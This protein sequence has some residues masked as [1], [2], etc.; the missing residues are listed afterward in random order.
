M[1]KLYLYLI[2]LLACENAG[3]QTKITDTV[4]Y[5]DYW[6]ICEEPLSSYYRVGSLVDS[7]GVWYFTGPVRDYT[8]KDE[9]L[10]EGNYS[11]DGLR[12]GDFKFYRGHQKI[13]AEGKF[14]A[15]YITGIWK[16]Y[17]PNGKMR[18]SIY[19]PL[20]EKD[21]KFISLADSTGKETLTNGTGSFQWSTGPFN[22]F[23]GTDVFGFFENGRRKGVWNFYNNYS[24]KIGGADA[25]AY[26]ETYDEQG[27]LIAKHKSK[28]PP[29]PRE[30]RFIPAR[31]AV[32]ESL[33]FDSW[34]RS[35]GDSAV[36]QTVYHY[37][38]EGRTSALNLKTDKFENA[39]AL[40]LAI[41]YQYNNFFMTKK[42]VS[43]QIEFRIGPA[44]IPKIS[45]SLPLRSTA[46]ACLFY[47][48]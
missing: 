11:A 23:V 40:L 43:G 34:F 37:L 14:E 26:S 22:E 31:L 25:P 28:T 48:F 9:L 5:N 44:A 7:A 35:E 32:M 47:A 10:L 29:E 38:K 15:G 4:Y 13:I 36:K 33:D 41:L 6:Q 42:D 21:F 46:H 18:A 17:H 45:P 16:W 39:E 20:G 1:R 8:L 19:F 3:A 12:E 27:N 24:R 2:L 30:F